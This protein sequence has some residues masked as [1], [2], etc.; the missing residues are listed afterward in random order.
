MVVMVVMVVIVVIASVAAV[1]SVVIQS[2]KYVFFA[3]TK[4][5]NSI[6]LT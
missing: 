6:S 4:L 1:L 2:F 3:N 5:P